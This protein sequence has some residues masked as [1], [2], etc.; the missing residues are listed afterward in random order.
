MTCKTLYWSD[1]NHSVG[2]KYVCEGSQNKMTLRPIFL[3]VFY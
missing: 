2:E 1:I 3:N